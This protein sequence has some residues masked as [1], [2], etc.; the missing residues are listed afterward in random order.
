MRTRFAS[1]LVSAVRFS[2]SLLKRNIIG[3]SHLRRKLI[4]FT[5]LFNLLIGPVQASSLRSIAGPISPAS[6]VISL[7]ALGSERV[8]KA[9]AFLS[10]SKT[11]GAKKSD[12]LADRNSSVSRISISPIK[13]VGYEGETII[14][15]ALPTDGYDRTVQGVRFA[16]ESSDLRKLQIDDSGRATLLL[17][18]QARITCR[19][20]SASASVT[21]MIKPGPRPIQT[22]EQWMADQASLSVGRNQVRTSAAGGGLELL[23]RVARSL[24]HPLS[25]QLSGPP[26]DDI[27]SDA[28]WSDPANLTGNPRNRA[29]DYSRLGAILPEGSNFNLNIPL[30]SRK[31]R[32]VNLNLSLSYN[33]RVWSQR[34]NTITFDAVTS[35]PSPGFTLGFGRIVPYDI[36]ASLCKFMLVDPDG[37]RHYLG[38]GN[39][40]AD[41]TYQTTDGTHITYVGSMVSGGI[42]YFNNGSKIQYTNINNRLLAERIQDSNGNEITITYKPSISEDGFTPTPYGPTAI[43]QITDTLGR[44]VQFNYDQASGKPLSVT[45]PGFGGSVQ[46]PAS[47]TIVQFDYQN[48]SVTGG[49]SGLTVEKRPAQPISVLR[50]VYFP[51]TNTGYLFDYS[52]Y[53]M[54]Y[55]YSVRRQMSATGTPATISDGVESAKSTFD[56]PVQSSAA[57]TAPPRFTQRTETAVSAQTATFTYSTNPDDTAGQTRTFVITRPDSST[58]SLSRS[59]NSSSAANG[60]LVQAEV[61]NSGG[62]SFAK[63]V[64]SYMTDGG[65]SPQVQSVV[66]SDD[67]SPANQTKVDFDYDQYGNIINKR[68]YGFQMSGEWRVQRRTRIVYK[69]DS[70]YVNS[71][72]RSLPIEV[73]VYDAQQD[74]SDANDILIAKS[75]FAY[76]NYV[77]MGGME[78]YQQQNPNPPGY[79]ANYKSVVL[80]GNLTG[81]S[82]YSD[83]ANNSA[84]THLAKYDIFG[85]VVK[86]QVSCC[87]IK[88]LTNTEETYWSQ[89]SEV[90]S[91]EPDGLHETTSTDYDFNT[92]VEKSTKNAAGLQT[93]FGYDSSLN[94]NSVTL[95]TGAIGTV[96]YDYGTLSSRSDY[97]YLDDG[98]FKT[99]TATTQYNGWGQEIQTINPNNAQINT[100]YDRMGRVSSKTN[101]F[102]SGGRPG[103]ATTYQYDVLGRLTTTT[104][105]DGNLLRSS[106]SGSTTTNT[107][108]VGRQIKSETDGLGR[109]AKVTE[110]DNLGSLTQETTY[111]YDLL[112]NLVLVNKGNQTRSYKY[113]ALGR[114]L[115]ERVP[116]QTSTINDGNGQLWTTKYTYTEFNAVQ[117]KQDARGVV[118]TYGYDVL[119]RI[120]TINYETSNA[121]GVEETPPISIGYTASG[122]ISQVVIGATST[123]PSAYTEAFTYD[124]FDRVQS[125]TRWMLGGDYNPF[126]TYTTRYEHNNAGQ[127][128]KITYP[129][130]TTV[131]LAY[132]NLGRLKSMPFDPE[133]PQS[134]YVNNITYNLAGQVTGLTLANGVNETY[135]Y[136]SQRFQLTGQ[137][138]IRGSATLMDLAYS[139]QAQAGQMGPGTT[140]GNAGQLMSITGT[141]NASAE[142]ASYT[143]D[144]L[145]RLVTSDQTSNGV[146]AARR[147]DYD[148]WGNRKTVWDAVSGGRQIQTMTM[149]LLGDFRLV[150]TNRI[151][152]VTNIIR[153]RVGVRSTVSNYNYDAA[154]N[155]TNDGQ[156]TYRYDAENRLVSVDGGPTQYR[157][158][159][160][161]RRVGKLEGAVWISYIWEGSHVVAEHNSATSLTNPLDTTYPARSVRAEYIYKGGRLLQS[162]QYS[163]EGQTRQASNQYY[164][165]DRLSTRLILD[166][167]GNV[168]GKQ[169]HLPFGEDFAEDGTQE[170][171]HFASYER[172]VESGLDYAL[173]RHYHQNTGRFVSVDKKIG[174]IANPQRLNRFA[175]AGNDPINRSDELGL[176]PNECIPGPGGI[177][178][179]TGNGGDWMDINGGGTASGGAAGGI[180]GIG[181]IGDALAEEPAP[182]DGTPIEIEPEPISNHQVML[183]DAIK[184]VQKILGGSN[185]CS[186]FFLSSAA[187]LA[188]FASFVGQLNNPKVTEI[189]RMFNDTGGIDVSTGIAMGGQYSSHQDFNTGVNYRLFPNIVINLYGPFFQQVDVANLGHTGNPL[190]RIG[191]YE[192]G[193]RQARVLQL[194]HELAHLIVNPVTHKYLIGPDSSKTNDDRSVKNTEKVEKECKGEIDAL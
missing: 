160:Q 90:M 2:S 9:A 89:A 27:A 133:V 107:D 13:Y 190:P 100:A 179:C 56:Y 47:Q 118:K 93:N 29:V 183:Q 150:P 35:W 152:S 15:S 105:P 102:P 51:A 43:D 186:K 6:G 155:V 10:V 61:K 108:Q 188:V 135:S 78:D 19:A 154:G 81:R 146:S 138:A 130:G 153:S 184:D 174:N 122:R 166:A 30:I 172:D 132:D 110:P 24:S 68:E 1:L 165:K 84:I 117:T 79:I 182:G 159:D 119:N 44:I 148:L 157:Y 121:P 181:V 114:L 65:G 76:D 75:T 115:F 191:H 177:Y 21:V 82:E 101:P 163:G 32:G 120:S 36:G 168:I 87:Q 124:Q 33:S 45:A 141:I 96:G 98:I 57:L 11:S 64:F 14:F 18:G 5:L 31:G 83:L 16:W 127:L 12:T 71:Y 41:G 158:D 131:N 123:T 109:L 39:P 189:K 88:N 142:S 113:D 91:G 151:A 49:F 63:Y 111:S 176:D 139:Y 20:G 92:G 3:D 126:K 80:R 59:T 70:N 50:H 193:S 167:A 46:N 116:E 112:D 185:S 175:Y 77:A 147:F 95:P 97:T 74:T 99:N 28:L 73:D 42:L 7:I 69:T 72:L 62:A 54:I 53:G 173:N 8:K 26:R 134:G 136:D 171:H 55:N 38:Q 178:D 145:R 52:S 58:V 143:Y 170:K 192:P 104:L 48:L 23:F 162:T 129:S 34:G 144:N 67:A 128:K 25:V 17:A 86:A 149:E 169:G 60:L 161:N 37:T 22:D 106:Y 85:N 40:Q 140:A 66:G 187:A 4:C 194:L 137:K 164:L 103:P 156:H 180:G 94:I 125:K